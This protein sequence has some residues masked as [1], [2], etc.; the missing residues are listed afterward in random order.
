M[1][2]IP[3]LRLMDKVTREQDSN[4]HIVPELELAEW[5]RQRASGPEDLVCF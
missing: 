1:R 2:E 3:V 4:L 5:S